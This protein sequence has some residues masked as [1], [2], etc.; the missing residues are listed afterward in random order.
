MAEMFQNLNTYEHIMCMLLH[1]YVGSCR[2]SSEDWLRSNSHA[3]LR[4]LIVRIG[5]QCVMQPSVG[6]TAKATHYTRHI[7]TG[8][9]QAF[10]GVDR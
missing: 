5:L 9:C 1:S 6:R 7:P 4:H 10:E 3:P 2:L 8:E